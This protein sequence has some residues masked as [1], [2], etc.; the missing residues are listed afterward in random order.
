MLTR[1]TSSSFR[2]LSPSL[3]SIRNL[4]NL[5]SKFDELNS[6]KP[7]DLNT[8]GLVLYSK[9]QAMTARVLTSV[10]FVNL[11]VRIH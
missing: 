10:S 7:S 11:Y 2:R 9:S 6:T 3:S 5:D 8:S 1:I 4:S